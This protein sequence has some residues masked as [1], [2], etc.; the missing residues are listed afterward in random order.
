MIKK[1][2]SYAKK[3]QILEPNKIQ[4]KKY[5]KAV[6]D[7]TNN[8]LNH[9]NET[10]F[11]EYDSKDLANLNL[12]IPENGLPISEVLEE[13]DEKIITPGLH[14][15]KGGHFAYIPGGGMYPSA[16]GDFLAAVVNKFPGIFYSGPGPVKIEN[17][18]V[19]WVANLIGYPET[20]AGNISSGGSIATLSAIVAARDIHKI[21]SKNIT[22][23][24]I[25]LTGQAHHCLHKAIRIAGL[26]EVIM[27]YVPTDDGFRMDASELKNLIEEDIENGL[28]PFIIIATIGTTD[29]GVVDPIDAIADLAEQ[30]NIWLH[31]DAAYGGFFIL[32]DE[33][34]PLF[35]GVERSDSFVVD[36]HKGLFLPFGSGILVVRDY[37]T[38][39]KSH[40]YLPG[41]ANYMQDALDKIDLLSPADLSPEL[42]KHNRGFRMWLPLKLYGVAPFKAA[43]TEKVYLS[44][45][46][47]EQITKKGFIVGP[48]PELSIAIFRYE[49]D[50]HSIDKTNEGNKQI[51]KFLQEEGRIFLSSTMIEGIYWIRFCVLGY[52]SHLADVDLAI[53]LVDKFK[54]EILER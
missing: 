45:Y 50:A 29:T 2:K 14:P 10:T 49:F 44:R 26:G 32:V 27:R 31:V 9:P 38:L 34:K 15:T 22:K 53:T 41:E 3:A 25:Y 16:L 40:Q 7:Y 30:H 8:Y 24:V 11:Q 23:S 37:Q 18:L 4:R 46:F 28:N 19:K 1:I 17:T 48:Y 21:N 51:V 47:Q 54:E 33:L 12:E 36:P 5:L 39:Y 52:K 20:A 13:L 43:L 42:T 6:I 35:K